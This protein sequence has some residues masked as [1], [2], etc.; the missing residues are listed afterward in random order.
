M[1]AVEVDAEEGGSPVSPP[2]VTPGHS[3]PWV[4]EE[5][6]GE[7]M[8]AVGVDVGGGWSPVSPPSVTPGHSLLC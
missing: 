2:T 7:E 1:A 5:V 3:D 6:V 8:A 4:G